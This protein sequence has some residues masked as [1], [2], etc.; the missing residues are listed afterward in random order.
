MAVL[1]SN[2]LGGGRLAVV[3][4]HDPSVTPVDARRGSLI[5]RDG[6]P[7]SLFVK[8]DDGSSTDVQ[9]VGEGA[10]GPAALNAY[11]RLLNGGRL[12]VV[13]TS[14]LKYARY[15]GAY[16][17]VNGSEVL[18]PSEGVTLNKSDELIDGN[19][20]VVP[21]SSGQN[22]TTYYIY[23]NGSGVLRLST[24]APTRKTS[25]NGIGVYYLG[26]AGTPAGW[27]C[28]G[29]CRINASGN[30]DDTPTQRHLGN[31][32]NKVWKHFRQN[33]GRND[34]DASSTINITSTTWALLNGGTDDGICWVTM[35]EA[36]LRLTLFAGVRAP[37]GAGQF[38]YLGLGVN[39]EGG[40]I[41]VK[42]A[43][44]GHENAVWN[45]CT[46][47][48]DDTPAI[49]YHEAWIMAR[50]TGDTGV[51][52]ADIGRFGQAADPETGGIIGAVEV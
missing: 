24:T 45:T 46:I 52:Y 3:V 33:P 48:Y 41:V 23:I 25:G 19:G 16:I 51:Y 9:A 8:Q 2:D 49:G 7:P 34:N 47:P 31:L 43:A 13:T 10:A 42:G 14:Q 11:E 50:V 4:D 27:K 17:Y 36:G 12:E 28:L 30:F 26:N 5:I 20:D 38:A 21:A 44:F 37:T 32:Y 22:S 40:S 39:P 6:A 1:G 29:I 15:N 35:G 18:I